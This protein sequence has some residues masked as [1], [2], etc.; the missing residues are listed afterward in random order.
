MSV[1]KVLQVEL[2]LSATADQNIIVT[3]DPSS[4]TANQI[5]V[6]YSG[7]N[8][9][10]PSTY[11]NILYIWQSGDAI[12]WST[13]ALD[14]DSLVGNSP[15]GSQSFDEL[16][17][18]TLSYIIGYG[19]GPLNTTGGWSKYNNVVASVFVPAIG[20]G[21]FEVQKSTVGVSKLG[22]TSLVAQIDMLSGFNPAG[23]NTWVGIWEGVA[24]SYNQKPKWRSPA[25]SGNA[26]ST[27]SFNNILLT[28]GTTYTLGLFSSGY[29]AQDAQLKQTTLAA[30]H[31]FSV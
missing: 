17:V 8:A 5:S 13:D 27:V 1:D 15:S 20:G 21:D 2:G 24:A 16:D 7:P 26:S 31:T 6:D 9:N 19:V 28:R 30:T 22:S 10:Q 29:S 11:G 23:S 18:T 12:P 14:S 25:T 4:V 3:T